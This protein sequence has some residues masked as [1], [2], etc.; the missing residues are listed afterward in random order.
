[1]KSSSMFGEAAKAAIFSM[2]L[3][4]T[5]GVCRGL[6]G[7]QVQDPVVQESSKTGTNSSSVGDDANAPQSKPGYPA[8]VVTPSK[9]TPDKKCRAHRDQRR[10]EGTQIQGPIVRESSKTGTNSSSVGRDTN[11]G[12]WKPGDPVKVVNPSKQTAD[13]KCSATRDQTKCKEGQTSKK[14]E[15]K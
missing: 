3:V 7:T 8:K 11:V 4:T 1:V 2:L 14:P 13:K 6:E 5:S 15:Q 9:Q 10:Q 12:Q